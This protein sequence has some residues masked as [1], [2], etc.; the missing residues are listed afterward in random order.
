MHICMENTDMYIEYMIYS[1]IKD[2]TSWKIPPTKFLSKKNSD[3]QF[4]FR[5]QVELRKYK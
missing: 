2:Q 5:N 4:F 1:K 3:K